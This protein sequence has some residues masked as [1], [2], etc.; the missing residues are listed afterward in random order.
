VEVIFSKQLLGIGIDLLKRGRILLLPSRCGES[1]KALQRCGAG[2]YSDSY[3]E[4]GKGTP[5][6]TLPQMVCLGRRKTPIR[7]QELLIYKHQVP[8]EQSMAKPALPKISISK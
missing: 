6:R 5:W 8:V 2:C 4:S 1:S 3:P 7:A